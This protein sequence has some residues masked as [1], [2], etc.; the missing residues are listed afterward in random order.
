MEVEKNKVSF[1]G[2][3]IFFEY[4]TG[5]SIIYVHMKV[6]IDVFSMF[7]LITLPGP[8]HLRGAVY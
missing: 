5:V 1:Y 6:F 8:G 7:G 3:A 4:N 2:K